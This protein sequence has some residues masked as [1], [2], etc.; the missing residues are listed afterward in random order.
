MSV[1]SLRGWQGVILLAGV[2]GWA[3]VSAGNPALADVV[4]T[5]P[6]GLRQVGEWLRTGEIF[7]HLWVTVVEALLGFL[8]GTIAGI[9][10]G[11]VLTFVPFLHRLLDPLISILATVP[12]IVLA[13]I[14]MVWFGLGSPSKIALF[15]C[16][17]SVPLIVT[18][19]NLPLNVARSPLHVTCSPYLLR[20]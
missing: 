6:A 4:G 16:I 5:P 12:R 11:F 20:R 1:W 2:G 13:P 18:T 7:A 3:A 17:D 9:I 15:G 10:A 8:A 14:F 19:R